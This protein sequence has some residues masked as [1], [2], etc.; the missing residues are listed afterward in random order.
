MKSYPN[1]IC[2]EGGEVWTQLKLSEIRN[3]S[4]GSNN[5]GVWFFLLVWTIFMSFPCSGILICLDASQPQGELVCCCC[6]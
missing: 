5:G 6:L 2:P 1:E 3:K 4:L